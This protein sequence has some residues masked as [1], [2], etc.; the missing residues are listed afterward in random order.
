MYKVETAQEADGRWIAEVVDVPGV[1]AYGRTIE[2]AR[3]LAEALL[4]RVLYE[5]AT[6]G[7]CPG[8]AQGASSLNA[9]NLLILIEALE[10]LAQDADS[11]V[12]WM[13][14][15]DVGADELALQ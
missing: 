10:D 1:L 11:Q 5:R 9:S 4:T 14:E 8:A 15:H 2:E 13:R 6:G 12:A 7:E 3:Q